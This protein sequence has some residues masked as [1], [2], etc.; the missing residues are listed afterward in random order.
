MFLN[1]KNDLISRLIKRLQEIQNSP[2]HS[3]EEL[4][5]IMN[6]LRVDAPQSNWK[7]FE[8]QFIQVHPGFYQ[9]L[10]EKHPNLTTYEQRICAFLRMN[11][12]TKEVAMITGRSAKSIEV[13]RSRIRQ[14]L[15]LKRDDNLSS[16]LAAI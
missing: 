16:F 14:K 1:Q 15:N 7:E 5:S 3:S 10:Y 8:T 4:V 9:Q 6:E 12:N 13:A 11:L 2:D